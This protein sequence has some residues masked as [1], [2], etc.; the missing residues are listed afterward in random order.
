MTDPRAIYRGPGGSGDAVADTSN[1]SVTAVN[2]A[3]EAEA[4]KLAAAASAAAAS[5]SASSAA[6]S[7]SNA[8][9]SA[10]NSANSAS[11]AQTAESNAE[12][13][14]TNAET[15]Q[16]AAELAETN[17]SASAD[18]AE[19]W[20][21]KTSGPVSG[22]EYS[23]KY[24][25]N[26]SYNYSQDSLGYRNA[27]E[28]FSD[29]AED[30]ADLAASA[31]TSAEMARD[32]TLTAFDNFD[33]RYL[34]QKPS[35]PSLD[36]DN[37]AL[38]AGALYF[39]TTSN[40][41]KVYDGATWLAAYA[42]LS[43]AL[44]ATNNLSDLANPN[45][46]R[47]NL[48]VAIGTDVQAYDADL[49]WVAAN[50]TAAGKALLDDSS[51]SNQRT[52][53]G[54]GTLATQ[55]S[56]SVSVTGGTLDNVEITNAIGIDVS[57]NVQIDGNLTVSGSTVTLNTTN[58]AVE[59]NMIYLNDGATNSNPDLGIAGN[60]NDGTY[61]HAGIFRDATDGRWKFFH[62]YVPEP[63]ASVYIDTSHATFALANVEANSFIGALVGNADTVTN[64]IY[65]SGSYSN[66][67]WLTSLAGAKITGTVSSA[68]SA[69]S[70]TTA[71][72]ASQLSSTNWTVSEVSGVLYFAYL[73]V[74][75]AKL[76]SSGN[77]TVVGNVTA[78]GTV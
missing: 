72:S 64:G 57:G 56:N 25:A 65:S 10:T 17:A 12:T 71:T 13:A 30:S 22:S 74:N 18:L 68:T 2:A 33:D 38:L 24:N 45:T 15:A 62:Q 35:D 55:N 43:G 8:S 36:N 76:D 28:V 61:R 39:N 27:A 69:T 37:N 46:S 9:T 49:D 73:G 40:T 67:T 75:K 50:I 58:L 53:L 5:A 19:D 26:L 21:I 3:A 14:E 34:G 52:T 41:M 48:G 16:A 29:S 63:D 70:A 7:A 1:E 42:S 23:S 66:P 77:F 11:A 32:Q 44:L 54:L 60:Y 78:Y 51:A 20:A 31:K 59:D 4:S 47:T 6:T